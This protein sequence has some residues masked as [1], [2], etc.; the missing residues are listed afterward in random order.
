MGTASANIRMPPGS[1]QQQARRPANEDGRMIVERQAVDSVFT[2]AGAGRGGMDIRLTNADQRK[3]SS[4]E[5]VQQLQR[6]T[7]EAGFAGSRVFVRPPRIRGRRTSSAG[8]DVSVAIV[9][10]QLEQLDEIG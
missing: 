3:L 9:G 4:D 5:W 6:R 7:D 1:T 2:N 10:D 8:T